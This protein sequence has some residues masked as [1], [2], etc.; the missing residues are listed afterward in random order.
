VRRYEPYWG[1]GTIP[2][3]ILWEG[4]PDDWVAC[5]LW[6]EPDEVGRSS[7][8]PRFPALFLEAGTSFI[9]GIYPAG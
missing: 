1:G 7:E 3:A 9:L 6:G 4:G 8:P 2:Y 5:F